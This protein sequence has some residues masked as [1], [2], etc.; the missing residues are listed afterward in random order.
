MHLRRFLFQTWLGSGAVPPVLAP[1][2]AALAAE[3]RRPLVVLATKRGRE[4][5]GGALDNVVEEVDA[6]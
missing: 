6:A 2:A 4:L 1:D 5:C 3:S